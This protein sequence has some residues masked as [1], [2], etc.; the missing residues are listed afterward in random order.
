[1]RIQTRLAVGVVACLL[2]SA[3]PTY[4]TLI[5]LGD[6]TIFSTDLQVA[7]LRDFDA[8]RTMAFDSDGLLT[9]LQALAWIDHLN[10]TRYLGY[11]NWQLGSGSGVLADGTVQPYGTAPLREMAN[12]LEHLFYVEIGNLRGPQQPDGW[13]LNPGPFTNVFHEQSG[14]F[15]NY[16]AFVSPSDCSPMRPWCAAPAYDI[17]WD[18]YDGHTVGGQYRVTAMRQIPPAPLAASAATTATRQVPEPSSLLLLGLGA[19]VALW[20]RSG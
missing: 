4:A 13:V 18:R 15:W 12:Y 6:G 7:F 3:R 16:P 19:F 10:T 5:D 11:D 2:L 14:W 9:Y 1:M 8:P 17:E 20:R